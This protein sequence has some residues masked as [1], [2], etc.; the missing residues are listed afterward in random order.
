MNVSRLSLSFLNTFQAILDSKPITQFRSNNNK[1]LLVYLALQSERS[2]PREVLATL[3]WPEESES[4]ARNNLRQSLHQLRKVLG[5]LE[6]PGEAYLLVTRQTVQFNA[7]SDF[8]LD[9]N[10]FWQLVD[11]GDLE[12]ATAV[13]QGD[14]LPGFTC[15]SLPFEDWLRHEREQL[16]QAA[17]EAMSEVTQEHLQ[18]G[19]PDKAQAVAR[20]QLALEPWRESACRQLMQAYALAGDRG[21]AAAPGCDRKDQS[22]FT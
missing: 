7:D 14:L 12:A 18:A 19:R 21:N 10:H 3:F 16:H 11:R 20:Q 13:Y 4:N 17:L 2:F 22:H 6:N 5:D 1:G 9:V 8:N 15:D